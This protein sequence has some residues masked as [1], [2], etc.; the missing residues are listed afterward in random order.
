METTTIDVEMSH[1]VVV[2][3]RTAKVTIEAPVVEVAIRVAAVSA[4]VP[5]PTA[6]QMEVVEVDLTVVHTESLQTEGE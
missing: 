3:A 4:E 1:L 5:N 6:T 2:Q